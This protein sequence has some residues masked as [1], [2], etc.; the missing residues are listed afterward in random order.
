MYL[1]L[2]FVQVLLNLLRKILQ[3][4]IKM[5]FYSYA[6]FFEILDTYLLFWIFHPGKSE[7]LTIIVT[8]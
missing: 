6:S 8:D 1:S 3:R 7:L 2:I 5:L 4:L